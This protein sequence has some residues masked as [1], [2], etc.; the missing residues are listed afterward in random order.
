MEKAGLQG[1]PDPVELELLVPI[2]THC[3]ILVTEVR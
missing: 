2:G 3:G 1:G